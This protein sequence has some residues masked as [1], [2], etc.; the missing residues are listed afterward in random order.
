MFKLTQ[1]EIDGLPLAQFDKNIIIVDDEQK[2]S[3]AVEA[4]RGQSVLGFDT[5][6]RPSFK[7]GVSY[8]VALLQLSTED[9]S[10]LIRLNK[11]PM[12]DGLAN[13]LTDSNILKAGVA[14][15]DDVKILQRHRM[16]VPGGF[17]DLQNM[18][19]AA[20][21][22]D[23]SLKKLAAHILGVRISKRQR[24]SNW[25]ASELTMAQAHYAATDSWISLL[26]YLQMKDEVVEHERIIKIR[27]QHMSNQTAK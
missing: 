3:E 14:I 17:V 9:T 19:R 13:I 26:I 20:G 1:E 5:E 22:E 10:W 6:T 23:F 15:R 24:L 27:K 18:A 25:E 8:N 21:F 11:V 7:R 12:S 4:M 2:M 16:F